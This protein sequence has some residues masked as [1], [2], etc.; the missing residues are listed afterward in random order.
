MLCTIKQNAIKVSALPN[1]SLVGHSRNIHRSSRVYL[2]PSASHSLSS[3]YHPLEGFWKG[4]L[5]THCQE[6]CIFILIWRVPS[7]E[8]KVGIIQWHKLKKENKGIH[9]V[10]L[11]FSLISEIQVK[12]KPGV[13][14]LMA[15][16]NFSPGSRSRKLLSRWLIG[17]K[18]GLAWPGSVL[19]LGEVLALMNVTWSFKAAMGAWRLFPDS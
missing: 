1:L 18:A 16:K 11:Q 12:D 15:K 10:L 5:G 13:F 6:I 2:L 9:P 14:H 3:L 8:R 4:G 17:F 7:S 19:E